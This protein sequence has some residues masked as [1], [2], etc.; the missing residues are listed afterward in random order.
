ML[1]ILKKHTL[2]YVEDEPEVQDNINEYLSNYFK[3]VYLAK[4]GKEALEKYNKHQ[5]DVILLDINIPYING[6]EVAT[7][8]RKTNKNIKIIM[9]TAFTETD[10]LLYATE[11]KLTKY[12]VKPVSP[13]YFKDCLEKLAAELN[14][15][16][17]SIVKIG[18]NYT[19]NLETS[20]LKLNNNIINLSEKEHKLLE[21]FLNHKGKC[22]QIN[23][24][25]E[26]LWENNSKDI[27]IASVK[28]QV[29]MLRKKLPENTIISIYGEG[30][31]LW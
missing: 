23:Q 27:S 3:T 11:L 21:L 24:I 26:S 4:D 16:S 30:Y 9:L 28:N 12:L 19:Y 1:S 15:D 29:S 31:I 17:K 5:P 10:K 13:N 25:A 8:I 22:L 6:L 14:Y 20:L 2:L 7:Q 18:L